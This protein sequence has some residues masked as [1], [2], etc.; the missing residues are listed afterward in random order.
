VRKELFFD[1]PYSHQ[2]L[3][4]MVAEIRMLCQE[5][6][7]MNPVARR[8]WRIREIDGRPSRYHG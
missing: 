5:V 4:D 8:M 7:L 1:A 3:R 6:G 2:T